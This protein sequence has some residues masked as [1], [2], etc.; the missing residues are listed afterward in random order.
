MRLVGGGAEL[1]APE[2]LVVGDV[3]LEEADLA[4]ALEGQDV[5]P[6]R[7]RNQ[8]SWLMT[9]TQPGN[10]SSPASSARNVS[11]SRSLVGSSSSSTLPPDWSSLARWTRF[12][13][14]PDSAPTSFCWS[15]PRKLKL[16]TYA[17]AGSSREPAFAVYD[18][19]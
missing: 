3:A 19:P 18:G 8:R 1:L 6:M 2:R 13:S 10:D 7:S 12:L 11:T 16:D 5:R 14:P 9:T 15:V 17:R 4:V